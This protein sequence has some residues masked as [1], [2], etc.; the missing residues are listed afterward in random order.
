MDFKKYDKVYVS[1]GSTSY[2]GRF[3][4]AVGTVNYCYPGGNKVG[5]SLQSHHNPNSDHGWY[6]FYANELRRTSN[7]QG[8]T[9]RNDAEPFAI[10]KVYFNDPVTVVLWADGSKTVVKCGEDDIY[11]P[12]KGL[13]MAISKKALGNKGNY[14]NTFKKHL[15]EEEVDDESISQLFA[16]LFNSLFGKREED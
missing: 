2:G 9:S 12:E 1:A 16:D 8:L 3:S 6:Y 7:D 11:D 14:Y 15:P 5:V 13:A 4:G 10:K